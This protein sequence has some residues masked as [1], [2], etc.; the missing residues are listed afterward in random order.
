M[1]EQKLETVVEETEPK[2]EHPERAQKTEPKVEEKEMTPPKITSQT[3]DEEL[4]TNSKRNQVNKKPSAMSKNTKEKQKNKPLRKPTSTIPPGFLSKL[5]N[6]RPMYLLGILGVLIAGI[7]LWYQRKSYLSDEER[8]EKEQ[9]RKER[10]ARLEKE[11]IEK[12]KKS[13]TGKGGNQNFL[14][15]H[16]DEDEKEIP[17]NL[18]DPWEWKKHQLGVW[19]F[20]D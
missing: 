10:D 20:G 17:H 5:L 12:A 14:G 18:P 7:C 9:K 11:R 15:S 16:S 3:E 6:I 2:V 8:E 19:N 13:D 4:K 1:S